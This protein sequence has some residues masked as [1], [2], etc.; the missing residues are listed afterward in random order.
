VHPGTATCRWRHSKRLAL[1]GRQCPSDTR[2]PVQLTRPTTT[3]LDLTAQLV[4]LP[5][6]ADVLTHD[7]QL[8][9]PVCL[10]ICGQLALQALDRLLQVVALAGVLAAQVI[11]RAVCTSRGQVNNRCTFDMLIP[12][13]QLYH[14]PCVNTQQDGDPQRSKPVVPWCVMP[15]L[16]WQT[17]PGM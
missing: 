13:A 8:V 5:N 17:C 14:I 6:E 4:E 1:L 2:L 12:L 10:S 9:G 16:L 7:A 11:A 15:L 3:H